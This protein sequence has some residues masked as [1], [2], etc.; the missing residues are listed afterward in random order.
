MGE[1]M[2]YLRFVQNNMEKGKWLSRTLKS[3]RF[4][5]TYKLTS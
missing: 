3:L 4:Y 1:I 5:L 2:K